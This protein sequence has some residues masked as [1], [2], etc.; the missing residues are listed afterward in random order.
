MS[1]ESPAVLKNLLRSAGAQGYL[2]YDKHDGLLSPM[3]SKAL[4][5]TR[6]GRLIAIQTVMRM[7]WNCRPML[8]I[9]K[10][11]NPKG[12]GLFALAN[13]KA[14]QLFG[15]RPFL[16]EAESILERLRAMA[17]R[18]FPGMSWGYQYPWQDAGFFAPVNFPNRVV[19]CWIGQAFFEAWKITGAGRYLDTC[20]EICAF[21]RRAPNR[22]RDT[23]DELCLSYVPDASVRWAVMDVSALC[24][25][26][27]AQTGAAAGDTGLVDDAHR[28][29]RYIARCQTLYGAWFY[30]EPPGDSSI[31]HDNYHT[32]II[33]D[34]IADY[35]DAVNDDPYREVYEKGVRYYAE[36]LFEPDGAPRWM[37]DRRYPYDIHGAAQGIISFSHPA[38]GDAYAATAERIRAWTMEN[39]YDSRTGEFWY[40]K[41][42]FFTKRFTFMRWCNGWMCV[43]LASY[44]QAHRRSEEA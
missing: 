17:C 24:G 19:T 23:A 27:F 42:R 30:T 7:P 10:S 20:K 22:I 14:Y 16:D 36:N 6:I 40:Q 43:A 31:T 34:C 44:L 2:G 3:L 37:N 15:D 29:L 4:G 9:A 13:L 26:M 5:K 11:C 8:G 28:C 33:L 1:P 35:H 12:L 39:I 41:Y 21:L 18:Q 38:C 32:G 25:R